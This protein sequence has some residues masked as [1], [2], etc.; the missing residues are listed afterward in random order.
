VS[1]YHSLGMVFKSLVVCADTNATESLLRVLKELDIDAEHCS[2][3]S[4]GQGLLLEE[5][6]DAVIFDSA[7]RESA[8]ESVRK[9]RC[10]QLNSSS[11]VIVLLESEENVRE[12][13]AAGANFVLYKPVSLERVRS[14]LQAARGMMQRE[15]RRHARVAV[16]TSAGLTYANVENTPATIVDLSE[17]GMAIQCERRLPQ[18][19]KVYF[20][21]ALPDHPD[22]I[23]LSGEVI[24]QDSSGRVGLRFADV[25]QASRRLLKAWLQNH[26]PL[27]TGSAEAKP[28]A[29]K[30]VADKPVEPE[31]RKQPV[32]SAL[33]PE[34]GL[35]RLRSLPGNRRGQSR[36]ACSLG[37]EVYQLGSPVPNRCRL[38]DISEG[39]CYVETPTPFA[40]ESKVEILVR[41]KDLKIR[42]RG[43]VQ[44]AHPGFGMGVKF[45]PRNAAER[46]QI[47]QLI[48]LL[49]NQQT[50]E[51]MF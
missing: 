9:V 37:A 44:S 29:A 47:E 2:H 5:R 14:S 1:T 38:S 50:L 42:T 43:V 26:L 13:F 48:N 17:E 7:D 8:I 16:H 28:L 32:A 25:P 18:P 4:I 19:G 23:R 33:N 21:F 49:E 12:V 39:G 27:K 51:P 6:Y 3:Q 30:P 24:W 36:H 31:Q 35:Q 41:T 46:D 11:L 45:N 34:A 22:L 20:Q 10:S 15:K 40:A